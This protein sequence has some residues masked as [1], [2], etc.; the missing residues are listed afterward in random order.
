MPGEPRR[1]AKYELAPGDTLGKYEILRKLAVGGM[2][3]LYLARI[4]GNAGF[5]KVVVLKRILPQVAEDATFVQMFLE[6][7]RLAGTLNHPNIAHVYDV[8]EVDGQHFF[9][10]EFVHGQDV[11]SIRHELKKESEVVPMGVALAVVHG[12]AAALDYAHE[13]TGPDGK[14]LGLVHRDVSASNVMVS[15]DGAIKLL[16]FGIA[17]AASSTHKTQVGTLKGKVPYMSPEQCKGHPLDRRSDLF[18]LGIVMFE[19]TVGRRPFRGESDFAVM[20]QIVYK[21]APR[22]SS[23]VTDYPEAL[24]AI[25]MKL[26]ERDPKARYTTGEELIEDIDAFIQRA[27]LWMSPTKIGKWMRG[28]FA[29]KIRAWEDAEQQGVSF[30]QH[31]A[32]SITSQSQ[33]SELVTPPSAFPGLPPQDTPAPETVP[34]KG[35]RR[36]SAAMAAVAPPQR[37]SQPMAAVAPPDGDVN[38]DAPTTSDDPQWEAP[39]TSRPGSQPPAQGAPAKRPTPSP[40]AAKRPTPRP[41]AAQRPGIFDVPTTELD[42]PSSEQTLER[43]S[44]TT[45]ERPSEPTVPAPIMPLVAPPSAP[46]AVPAIMMPHAASHSVPPIVS[47]RGMPP[48]AAPIVPMD[49]TGSAPVADLRPKSQRTIVFAFLGALVIGGGIGAWALMAKSSNAPAASL[50]SATDEVHATPTP[51][52]EPSKPQPAEAATPEPAKVEAAKPEAPKPEPAKVEAA[53]P[54]ATTPEPAKVEAAKPEATTPEPAKP[55]APRPMPTVVDKPRPRSAVVVEKPKPVPQ[56]PAVKKP[57]KP[58][59]QSWDPNSPFLPGQ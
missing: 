59:E 52:V 53:K 25:V 30:A 16:D 6:E 23:I 36:A 24:E 49:L 47:P 50:G 38:W 18:S 9:T 2:A 11:R 56:Q 35:S 3:E 13:R 46:V 39:T 20:D 12:T 21:G 14:L 58:K 55:V 28:L 32:H 33:R 43:S 4:R 34:E 57:V 41:M 44:E 22:P 15:Y 40:Q 37:T 10:M 54:E 51:I 31:V 1:S 29:E 48:Q 17:R 45:L 42:P 26:L 5:E 19:L 27:G 8:G 7:A